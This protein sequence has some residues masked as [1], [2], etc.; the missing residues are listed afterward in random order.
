MVE[1]T[2]ERNM[3][4]ERHEKYVNEHG[5]PALLDSINPQGDKKSKE[6]SE[7]EQSQ[8]DQILAHLKYLVAA[9]EIFVENKAHNDTKI[10]SFLKN[11]IC[12]Q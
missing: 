2:Y 3:A 10:L 11:E 8:N 5:I 4:L 9:S 12:G 7:K 6:F 1:D